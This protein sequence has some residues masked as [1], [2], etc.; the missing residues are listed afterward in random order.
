MKKASIPLRDSWFGF[1]GKNYDNLDINKRD[2]D[3]AK[4]FEV[5]IIRDG[6]MEI[7]CELEEY[8]IFSSAVYKWVKFLIPLRLSRTTNP[9][10]HEIVHVLQ[11]NNIAL[12]QSYIQHIK[13]PDNYIA[14]ISQRSETEAHFVQLMY[15]RQYEFPIHLEHIRREFEQLMDEALVAPAK[16]VGLIFYANEKGII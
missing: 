11:H 4:V 12:D 3:A 13:H 5:E 14:Y 16:R 7:L 2:L 10:I 15:I 6:K 9:L 8:S 1:E